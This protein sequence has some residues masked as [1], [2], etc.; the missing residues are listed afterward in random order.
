MASGTEPTVR[1]VVASVTGVRFIPQCTLNEATLGYL[2]PPKLHNALRIAI[3]LALYLAMNGA[4]DVR[5][6]LA[7]MC[8]RTIKNT[9]TQVFRM[10]R[11]SSRALVLRW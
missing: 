9:Q 6:D 5:R 3:L 4:G 2:S 11:P 7:V 8:P 10:A 1:P